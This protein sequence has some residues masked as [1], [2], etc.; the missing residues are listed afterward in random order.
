M[1]LILGTMTFGPQVDVSTGRAMLR[2][3]VDDGHREVDTAYVY[4]NGDSERMLGSLLADHPTVG[5][6]VAT[7]VNPRV[8]GRLDRA[9]VI[10]QCTESL[11]RMG[12]DAV[13]TLYLH[14]PDPRTPVAEALAA[15]AEL[16]RERRFTRLGLSNFAAADVELIAALCEREGW[17]APAVYQGLYNALGRAVE[18]DLIPVLRDLNVSF[19]AYNPLAGGILAGKYREYDEAPPPGRFTFRP[20][21][22]NRY[23]KKSFFDALQVLVTACASA[24][25]PLVH[26]AYRWL[27][28][29]SVLKPGRGDGII[30]GASSMTQFEQ[31]LD[32]FEGGA[33][34]DTIV[35]TFETAW[36]AARADAPGYARSSV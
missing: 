6:R 5:L 20:N 17:P 18:D 14:F 35:E 7:K 22:R 19:Y 13:D 36:Q 31:N 16:H 29:H 10:D 12:V 26:A 34:P 8:S 4:N 24:E 21:Y 9:A 2:R 32:A 27:A 11:R 23:W 1:K 30:L 15:C 28:H 33:M 3:F 25:I